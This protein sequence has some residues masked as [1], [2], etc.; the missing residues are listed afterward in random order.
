MFDHPLTTGYARQTEARPCAFVAMSGNTISM[1]S[2]LNEFVRVH[3]FL[4]SVG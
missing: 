3:Y 2:N 4:Y 1:V